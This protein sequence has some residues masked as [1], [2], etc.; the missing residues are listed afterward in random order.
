[1]LS[2]SIQHRRFSFLRYKNA[3]EVLPPALLKE[4]QRYSSGELLYIPQKTEHRASWGE[5]SGIKAEMTSRNNYIAKKYRAGISVEE[6]I[7][8]YCLSE[9]SIRKIIYSVPVNEDAI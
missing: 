7:D 5:L 3:R 9:S 4:I 6:L 1:M 2:L 8:E